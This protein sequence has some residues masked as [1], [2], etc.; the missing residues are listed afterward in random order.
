MNVMRCVLVKFWKGG[1]GKGCTVKG[2]DSLGF[3][4]GFAWVTELAEDM[5][6]QFFTMYPITTARGVQ[7]ED[8]L[9]KIA[10]HYLRTWFPVDLLTVIPFDAWLRGTRKLPRVLIFAI[11]AH[12]KS[13]WWLLPSLSMHPYYI[14][15]QLFIYRQMIH[16]LYDM[17]FRLSFIRH[18]YTYKSYQIIIYIYTVYIYV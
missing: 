11:F 18:H 7:W 14:I 8:S 2:K 1:E 10:K 16:C 12:L 15:Q 17:S 3:S 4:L 6:V 5:V 9:R 13:C